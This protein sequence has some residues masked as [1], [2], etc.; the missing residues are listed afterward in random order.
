MPRA[1]LCAQ[2]AAQKCRAQLAHGSGG[3]VGGLDVCLG[4]TTATANRSR[5]ALDAALAAQFHVNSHAGIFAFA[6]LIWCLRRC[7]AQGAGMR[8]SERLNTH[9]HTRLAHIKCQ[10]T[11]TYTHG[12]GVQ[13]L[14][15]L[16]SPSKLWPH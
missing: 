16:A 1:R 11:H 12:G 13:V 7:G 5:I 14:C 4:E 3:P 6:L 15:S 10:D 2:A 8:A 9:T